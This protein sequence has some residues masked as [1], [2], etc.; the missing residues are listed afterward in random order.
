[1]T[2]SLLRH[3]W[4]YT[5]LHLTFDFIPRS[6]FCVHKLGLVSEALFRH[7]FSHLFSSPFLQVGQCFLHH[8]FPL[9]VSGN[10]FLPYALSLFVSYSRG[11]SFWVKQH[12]RFLTLIWTKFKEMRLVALSLNWAKKS[13][14]VI[15]L[16]K[17]QYHRPSSMIFSSSKY[18][19]DN[20][21]QEKTSD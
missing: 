4:R 16:Q 14:E 5:V 13:F 11:F 20:P 10:D 21:W 6:T 12:R 1:M 15:Y 17:T 18:L 19:L 7:F 9:Q 3:K 2:G 8:F